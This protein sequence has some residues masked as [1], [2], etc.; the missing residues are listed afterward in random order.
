MPV[1]LA[2]VQ[3][4][5]S[6]T[7][8]PRKVL[9]PLAGEPMILRLVERVRRSGELD[10]V[11]VAT[12]DDPSDDPL[13]ALLDERGVLVRRGPLEDV[14]ARYL[15]VVDEFAP[16]TVVRLTGDNPLVDPAVIDEVL[17]AH[18]ASGAD[19]ASNSLVR[20]Y[21]YGLDVEAVRAEALRRV[22]ALA[23]QP[24]EREHVTIGIYRRP[25]QFTLEPVVQADDHAELRWTVDYPDDFAFVERVY[26]ELYPADPAFGQADVLA[27]LDRHPE[28]RRLR[29]DVPA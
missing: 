13:V 1:K 22:A 17:R 12:S 29:S 23:T 19:Y 25:E 3:A 5:C 27:L 2:I 20:S 18:S 7:R 10:E 28:L 26:N 8:M 4:R 24:E 9:M 11:V 15:R 16:E 6:S 21:P 14:L